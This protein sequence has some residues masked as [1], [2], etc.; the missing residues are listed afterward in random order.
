LTDSNWGA[1]ILLEATNLGVTGLTAED[2]IKSA[3]EFGGTAA[4]KTTGTAATGGVLTS[5]Y[6]TAI[7]K[8][9]IF[10]PMPM[11]VSTTYSAGWNAEN[12]DP[13]TQYPIKHKLGD[14]YGPFMARQFM[15]QGGRKVASFFGQESTAIGAMK[16]MGKVFNPYTELMYDSPKLRTFSYD[17]TLSPK[18]K[19]EA[20]NLRKIIYILKKSMHPVVPGNGSV[21]ESIIWE[22]PDYVDLTFVDNASNVDFNINSS[23]GGQSGSENSWLFK[24]KKCAISSVT[25][26][27]DNKFHTDG[28][29][30]AVSLNIQFMETELLT[31]RD[32]AGSDT[33][34]Y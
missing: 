27:Y 14:S 11:D 10:L 34:S 4:D 8:A 5:V 22:L 6:G 25:V 12:L 30:S 26:H 31:Q 29:P 9:L 24:M 19:G 28:S 18:N 32:Y 3:E 7:N 20:E 15:L 21:E 33:H 16:A 2:F 1:N 13:I 23:G 17:W